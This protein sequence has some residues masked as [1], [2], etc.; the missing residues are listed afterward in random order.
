VDAG[1]ELAEHVAQEHGVRVPMREQAADD[2]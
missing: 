1:Y 2:S